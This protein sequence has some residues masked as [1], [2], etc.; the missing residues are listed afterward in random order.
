MKRTF[1]PEIVGVDLAWGERK[2]DGVC[3]I[4]YNG[5]N[6]PHAVVTESY[7][8]TGDKSLLALADRLQEA[9]GGTFW[10]VDGPIVCANATGSRPVD[11]LTHAHFGK[12]HA[13]CHPANLVLTPRPPRILRE[14]QARGYRAGWDFHPGDRLVA[15][16]YPHPAMVRW[17]GLKRVLKYKR[18]PKAN[19]TAEF[20]RY[21]SLLAAWIARE[22]PWLDLA[23]ATVPLQAEWRKAV[24]DQLDALFCALIGL[25]HVHYHGK[26]TQ[27]LGDRSSGFILVPAAGSGHQE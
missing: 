2:P 17:F 6:P 15:E 18:P 13:G 12:Y 10:A 19:Q 4:A 14:L 25:W 9:P 1:H 27:I 3:V 11:K 20:Q 24:E 26:R 21:Q 8:S 5:R 16:V 22:F 23:E 7:L